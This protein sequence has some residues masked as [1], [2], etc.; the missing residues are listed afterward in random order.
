M[1]ITYLW[2]NLHT[3]FKQEYLPTGIQIIRAPLLHQ[4]NSIPA[5]IKLVANIHL[6]KELLFPLGVFLRCGNC[7][8]LMDIAEAI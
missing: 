1:C 3:E 5:S 2:S 6:V 8:S 7:V 4:K